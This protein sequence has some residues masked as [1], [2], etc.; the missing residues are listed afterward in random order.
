M[1]ERNGWTDDGSR[2]K[3]SSSCC[4]NCGRDTYIETLSREYCTSCGLECDYWGGGANKVYE[5]MCNRRHR[6]EELERDE[7]IRRELEEE[8]RFYDDED[9]Y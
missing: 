6:L 4:P 1:R 5:E 3:G 9:D 2:L 7:R 8:S